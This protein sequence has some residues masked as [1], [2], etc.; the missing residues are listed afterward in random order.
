[1][2][3]HR[4]HRPNK[5]V[6]EDMNMAVSA[7]NSASNLQMSYMKLLIAQMQNQNP[8]EPMSNTEMASQMAQFSQLEQLESMNTTFSSVLKST[9]MNYANS[10]IG[11]RVV[12]ADSNGNYQGATVKAVGKDGDDILLRVG[13]TDSTTNDAEV[14]LDDILAIGNTN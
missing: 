7:T 4:G 10:L 5:V 11:K 14:K 13:A 1:M 2:P 12:Y 9:Q 8:L 3:V 6:Q